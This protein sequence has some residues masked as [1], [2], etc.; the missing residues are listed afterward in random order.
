MELA[1]HFSRRF[2]KFDFRISITSKEIYHKT[3]EPG[4][5]RMKCHACEEPDLGEEKGTRVTDMEESA[6]KLQD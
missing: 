1:G 2:R 6:D 4:P 3:L 5:R